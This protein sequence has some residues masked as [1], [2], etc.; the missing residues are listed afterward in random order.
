VRRSFSLR[1]CRIISLLVT[2]RFMPLYVNADAMP[3]G[4]SCRE[5]LPFPYPFRQVLGQW[6]VDDSLSH[7][8]KCLT[9]RSKMPY[10][11]RHYRFRYRSPIVTHVGVSARCVSP[12]G[13]LR[14]LQ[15]RLK[16][17]QPTGF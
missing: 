6:L 15:S 13:K 7:L 14:S 16:L 5:P 1:S 8:S 4:M 2:V 17:Q 9:L 11:S 12:S 10:T 3:A